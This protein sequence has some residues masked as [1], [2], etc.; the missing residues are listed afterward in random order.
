MRFPT[1]C[2]CCAVP[3]RS[4]RAGRDP[5]EQRQRVQE[6]RVEPPPAR[7]QEARGDE[8]ALAAGVDVLRLVHLQRLQLPQS[9]FPSFS[10]MKKSAARLE[11]GGPTSL[12]RWLRFHSQ[13]RPS[14]FCT[15]HLS[16]SG[17]G[18]IVHWKGGNSIWYNITAASM[19][20]WVVLSLVTASCCKHHLCFSLTFRWTTCR[21]W[22]WYIL[23]MTV[24]SG[25][26]NQ[27][28]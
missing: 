4:P 21:W 25:S 11:A 9:E 6:E 15:G 12:S 18:L 23:S 7:V 8:G 22:L 1:F 13:W 5:A 14:L 24:W 16:K 2:P 17:S 28:L 19:K 27:T 20:L 10:W 3:S 26:P